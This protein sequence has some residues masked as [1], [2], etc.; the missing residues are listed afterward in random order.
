MNNSGLTNVQ[1]QHSFMSKGFAKS[2][3]CS[4]SINF[5]GFR[6][7]HVGI[8]VRM[9]GDSSKNTKEEMSFVMNTERKICFE[10][11][12]KCLYTSYNLR[13]YIY[14]T[15]KISLFLKFLLK[16]QRQKPKPTTFMFSSVLN[17]KGVL[18]GYFFLC[19]K[20]VLLLENHFPALT[21]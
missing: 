7:Q 19:H 9:N 14:R 20:K 3:F 21:T 18:R 11:F 12:I 8:K 4:K 1:F 6:G 2:T 13:I 5:V 10:I 17:L 15:L 16:F